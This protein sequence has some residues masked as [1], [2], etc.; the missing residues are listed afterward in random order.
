MLSYSVTA[1]VLCCCSASP[2]HAISLQNSPKCICSS[3]LATQM[4][5]HCFHTLLLQRLPHAR[6]FVS[7]LAQVHLLIQTCYSDAKTL[8]SYSAAAA[9]PPRTH[10]HCRTRPSASARP[11]LLLRCFRTLL[12][13]SYSVAAAPPPRARLHLRARPCAPVSPGNLLRQHTLYTLPWMKDCLPE[14]EGSRCVCVCVC[15]YCKHYTVC[16]KHIRCVVVSAHSVRCIHL[17]CVL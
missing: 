17:Q 8:L 15:V 5:K 11:D 9:P 14:P 3:R 7:E 16:C 1:F 2:T 10:L 4:L 6:V 13:L 12:L